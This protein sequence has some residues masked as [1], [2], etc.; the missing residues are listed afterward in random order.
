MRRTHTLT[1]V[2]AILLIV[3]SSQIPPTSPGLGIL[4]QLLLGIGLVGCL[5]A[6][7]RFIT[8]GKKRS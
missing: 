7:W 1:L 2:G 6:V 5:L 3:I 8:G 4:Q